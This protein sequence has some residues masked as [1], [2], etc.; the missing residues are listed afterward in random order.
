MEEVGELT[1]P[2]GGFAGP[3]GRGGAAHGWGAGAGGRRPLARVQ[4]PPCYRNLFAEGD[5]EETYAAW[6]APRPA[7]QALSR[8]RCV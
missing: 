5:A 6:K 3:S 7:Q 4:S 1:E 2:R 8:Y